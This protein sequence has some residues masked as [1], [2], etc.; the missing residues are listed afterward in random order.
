KDADTIARSWKFSVPGDRD[1]FA[2]KI[3]RLPSV[4]VRCDDDGALASFTVLDAAGFFNNQFTFVE[5]R[6][7][8]LA[9]RSELRLCQK[10]CFNFFCAQI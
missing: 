6:Q 4:G 1:Q 3:R 9:D 10:V 2:A 8:G 7:R 5:H